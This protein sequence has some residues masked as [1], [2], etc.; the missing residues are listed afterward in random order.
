MSAGRNKK[1]ALLSNGYTA[2]CVIQG[3]LSNRDLGLR[4]LSSRVYGMPFESPPRVDS[5]VV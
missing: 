2:P 1:P 4:D 5:C 3:C